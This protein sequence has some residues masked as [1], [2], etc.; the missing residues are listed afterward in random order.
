LPLGLAV[1]RIEVYFLLHIEEKQAVGTV[2]SKMV[3]HDNLC[4]PEASVMP[5]KIVGARKSPRWSDAGHVLKTIRER[6]GL[7]QRYVVVA[8]QEKY[9][10]AIFSEERELRR[11]EKGEARLKPRSALIFLLAKVYEQEDIAVFRDVLSKSR[12]DQLSQKEID[13][14]SLKYVRADSGTERF[15][16]NQSFGA[17]NKKM[18][19]VLPG[20]VIDHPAQGLVACYPLNGNAEDQS[21]NANHGTGHGNFRFVR[22]GVR[23]VAKLDGS[24]GY[25]SVPDG[26]PLRLEQFTLAAWVYLRK[27]KGRRRIIQKGK[28]Y[29][30]FMYH[31]RPLVGLWNE[32][33]IFDLTAF[34][35]VKMREWHFM[36]GTFDNRVL[37]F[38]L[39]G[40]CLDIRD[41]PTPVKP[42]QNREPLI[43]G[44]KYHGKKENYF[45]GKMCDVVIYNRA[46]TSREIYDLCK[47]GRS[48]SATYILVVGVRFAFQILPPW[49]RNLVRDAFNFLLKLVLGTGNKG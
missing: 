8:S 30:L 20:T 16:E 3:R 21:G 34:T 6:R 42:E 14:L 22:E 26:P 7:T 44:W 15:I 1:P 40:E 23:Q 27:T 11:V 33:G 31:D 12:Y 32:E 24:S 10:K 17:L 43:I 48:D 2:L 19:R 49:A 5:G 18:M 25:V 13:E 47:A 45:A 36:A 37:R 38:Y 4:F 41:F 46:L 35:Q 28:S 39:D 9:G 29:Y